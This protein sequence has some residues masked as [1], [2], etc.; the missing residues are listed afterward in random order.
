[1]SGYCAIPLMHRK[2]LP[3]HGKGVDNPGTPD[4]ELASDP[5][6]SEE[7]RSD[8]LSGVVTIVGRTQDGGTLRAVPYYAWDN[9]KAADAAQDW[10]AVWPKQA[11]NYRLRYQLAGDNRNGWEHKLYRPLVAEIR[12]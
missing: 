4:P 11:D 9:R 12:V 2:T 6:L 8:I 7:Y 10:M 1:M 3:K 5:Q